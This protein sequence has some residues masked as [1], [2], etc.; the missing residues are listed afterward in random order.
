M[1]KKTFK[2]CVSFSFLNTKI[3]TQWYCNVLSKCWWRKLYCKLRLFLEF[4]SI[5]YLY[6]DTGLPCSSTL[7]QSRFIYGL[8]PS[9]WFVLVSFPSDLELSGLLLLC[10][11]FPFCLP[12]F[13]VLNKHF[14]CLWSQ[15][16]RLSVWSVYCF[17]T[18]TLTHSD[19]TLQVLIE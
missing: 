18:S 5:K 16:L 13:S 17:Y 11:S 2:A 9:R 4:N 19:S 15:H 1:G 12:S 7:F 3:T 14:V 6:L 8:L 10:L